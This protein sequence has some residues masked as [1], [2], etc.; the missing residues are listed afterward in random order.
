MKYAIN[1]FP[2][3][4]SFLTVLSNFMV[5]YLRYALVITLFV[6]VIIFFLRMQIDQK[7][8]DEQS[9]MSQKKAI[10]QATEGI[11]G[12][13]QTVQKKVKDINDI[14]SKQDKII[15]IIN[16]VTKVVPSGMKVVTF[17][18]TSDSVNFSA[19][20]K[21]YRLIQGIQKRLQKEARFEKIDVGSISRDKN[22]IYSLAVT[23]S[24]WKGPLEEKKEPVKQEP[25]VTE[26][27]KSE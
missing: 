24:G 17:E 18:I 3:R 5:Y 9:K 16:Y 21:E 20:T 25:V 7:L 22:G 23:L 14:L 1:L 10:V 12:D 2:S 8:V 4:K 6:V 27:V 13:L 15:E 19:T 11:R 26:A